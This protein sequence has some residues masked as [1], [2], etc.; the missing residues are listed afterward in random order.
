MKSKK[1]PKKIIKQIEIQN[2]FDGL[3]KNQQYDVWLNALFGLVEDYIPRDHAMPEFDLFIDDHNKLNLIS[4]CE[5]KV[6][7]DV[8]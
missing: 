3:T 5:I 8:A 1:L 4:K 6:N 2:S 7:N